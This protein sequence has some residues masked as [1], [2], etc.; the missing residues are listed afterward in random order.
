VTNGAE[1]D[2]RGRQ[3]VSA[4]DG[5]DEHV[6]L[7][8]DDG[9]TV[10]TMPKALVHHADTPLHLAFSSYVFRP[11]GQVLLTRRARGKRTWPGVLTNS[12]CGHPLPGENLADAVRRRLHT[13]LGLT[14]ESVELV[15]PRFRYRARMANGI[16]ENEL[17]PVFRV[18]TTGTPAPCP[19]EVDWVDWREWTPLR[20]QVAHGALRVSPW[21]AEQ[22]AE[23]GTLGPDPFEWPVAD[24]AELPSAARG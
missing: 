24:P 19:D 10:G 18:R 16:T 8:D 1:V 3:L 5:H 17:C 12:C 6:V 21:C 9:R 4:N 15:L 22:L 7:V 20:E 2:R 11:D 13:E 14:A 23:L